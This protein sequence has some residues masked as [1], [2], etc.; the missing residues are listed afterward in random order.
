MKDYKIL[1]KQW[2]D[3]KTRAVTKGEKQFIEN[4]IKDLKKEM[5]TKGGK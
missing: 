1:I 5:K 2:E 4:Q 3:R